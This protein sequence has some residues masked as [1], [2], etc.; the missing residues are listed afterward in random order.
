VQQ[1]KEVSTKVVVAKES[2]EKDWVPK[3]AIVDVEESTS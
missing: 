1:K 2:T 3:E